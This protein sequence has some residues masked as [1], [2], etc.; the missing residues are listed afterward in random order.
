M[1][2]RLIR[3]EDV[4]VVILAG[5]RGT[6]LMEETDVV[7]KPMVTI[8]NKPILLHIINCYRHFGFQRFIVCLGY[9]GHVIKEYF[10]NLDKYHSD[11]TFFGKTGE[12]SYKKNTLSDCQ[13][14]LVE[15]GDQ[16]STGT[17]LVRVKTYLDT[18]HFCTTYGDG[19]CDIPLDEELRF[20]LRHGKLG[21]IAGVHPP[22][23]FGNLH[24]N[25]KGMVVAF[26]E[27]KRLEH[28]YINGGFFI[29]RHEF[30]ERLESE[31]NVPLEGEPLAKLASDGEL[32]CY[33]HEG[34]WQCMD[35]QRE[36]EILESIYS[37]G[38]APWVKP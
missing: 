34:F 35:T 26:Q 16:S 17:R 28:D 4:P 29:F 21:T 12:F 14:D 23:R 32:V 13:I 18:P 33:R 37:S 15:T 11:M 7:P 5:G 9:K 6:R 19:L 24:V 1:M 8:G 20:H 38:N 22:A 27:K 25:L 36:R 30:L 31:K 3:P 10:I 2:Q